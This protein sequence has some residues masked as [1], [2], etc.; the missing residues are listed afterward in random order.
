MDSV[1]A[2]VRSAI[3][4][5]IRSKG[6]RSTERRLRALLARA[7][8]KGWRTNARDIIGTPDVVFEQK[9]LAVF[10]DGCFWHGCPKCYR[11]PKSKKKFWDTKVAEN[12]TRDKRVNRTLRNGGWT[13]IRSFECEVRDRPQVVLDKIRKKTSGR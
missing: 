10:V 4:S 2:S 6:N 7:G 11:R 5:K 9:R 13:V 12:Q 8:I 1:S 3:M